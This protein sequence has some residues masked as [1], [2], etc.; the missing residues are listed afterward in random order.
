MRHLRGYLAATPPLK[1]AVYSARSSQAD[2]IQSMRSWI[3][4]H[5][6]AT[7]RPEDEPLVVQLLFPH[8]KPAARVYIDDRAIRFEGKFPSLDELIYA[9]RVWNE[10][11]KIGSRRILQV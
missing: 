11:D 2:G 1:L 3:D 7:R 5:D 4:H 10:A 6:A 8:Y 9:F